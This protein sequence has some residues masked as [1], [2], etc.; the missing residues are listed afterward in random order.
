[1][2]KCR[3]VPR[4][5][6]QRRWCK[7]AVAASLVLATA[8]GCAAHSDA[9]AAKPSAAPHVTTAVSRIGVVRPSL[10]LAGIITPYRQVGVSSALSEPLLE[11]DVQEGERVGAGQI[12]ARLE[13]DDLQAQLASA[14]RVVA[15]NRARLSQTAYNA[16]AVVAQD[17]TSVRSARAALVQA[18][19]SLA[20]ARSDLRR[21]Q[22]LTNGGYLPQQ[23][24]D[25]QRTTV[26]NDREAVDSA[27]ASLRAA[28]ANNAANG[29]GTAAGEQ[30]AQIAAAV[31][32]VDAAAASAELL[33]RQMARATIVAPVDGVV[34]AVN[35]N[36]G[37]YPSGRQLF[38][39]EENSRVYAVLPAS[40][41]QAVRIEPG[42]AATIQTSGAAG[43]RVSGTVEAVL[44]QIQPGTT[45]FAVKV[46]LENSAYRLHAGMPVVGVVALPAVR[47]IVIPVSAFADDDRTSVLAVV[48]GDV[49]KVTV[50]QAASDGTSAAV[51]GL[52][53]GIRVV[54]DAASTS[55]APGDR[56]RF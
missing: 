23:T 32:A 15:E 40:T 46:L 13:T 17:T 27:A 9:A 43:V 29:N 18:Q 16:G 5:V 24:L 42:A 44:D 39:L 3:A 45:N 10:R 50:T 7:P 53:G 41:A 11:V 28:A 37:E 54:T 1:M 52:A 2:P 47:G 19:V 6:F 31:A 49:K 56:V 38:T 36:P 25:Q 35:A 26:A 22:G 12:L 51:L 8:S 20:G 33:R 55:V 34:E 48:N 14:R 30:Q 21:Y 4:L